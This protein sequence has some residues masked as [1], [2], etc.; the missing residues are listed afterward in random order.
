MMWAGAGPNL[1]ASSA[2]ATS[3]TQCREGFPMQTA[4]GLVQCVADH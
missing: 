1:E 3:R 2:K 4:D